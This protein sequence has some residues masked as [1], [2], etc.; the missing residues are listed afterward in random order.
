MYI[1]QELHLEL[2][3][4]AARSGATV[5]DWVNDALAKLLAEESGARQER[6]RAENEMNEILRALMESDKPKPSERSG[7]AEDPFYIS[8]EQT[9]LDQ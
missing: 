1:N 5:S 2:K 7:P 6:E 8:R 9:Y 4:K 3:I